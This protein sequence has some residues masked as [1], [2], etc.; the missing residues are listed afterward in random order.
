MFVKLTGRTCVVIGGGQVAWRK[1]LGLREC[2]ATVHVVAMQVV[3]PIRQMQQT[4]EIRLRQGAYQPNDL[5]DAFLVVAATNDIAVNTQIYQDCAA[6]NILCNV[7]DQP[8]LCHFYYAATHTC[9]DLKIA[10]S[11]N[12]GAPGISTQIKTQIAAL[13]PPSYAAYLTYIKKLRE[14]VKEKIADEAERK[15]IMERVIH[16]LDLRARAQDPTFAEH[17]AQLDY[18]QEVTRWQSR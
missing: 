8:E 16:D 13:Y 10:I 15:R 18:H 6:R 4:G 7:V 1:I 9:G 3:E 17:I 5:G 14:T 12:V 11:T 2:Q